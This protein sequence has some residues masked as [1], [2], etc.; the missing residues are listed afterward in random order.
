MK[1]IAIYIITYN[2]EDVIS[3][4]L[5]SILCQREW[6]LYRIVVSDDRS[7]DHTWEILQ[8]YKSQYPD[9]MDI[10]QNE[11]NLGIYPNIQKATSF[12]PECDLY[13]ALAGDDEYC[14]GY[15]ESIQKLIKEKDIDTSEAIG[16]YSDWKAI[17]PS[18][19]EIL[20]KQEIVKSGV[21]LWSLKARGLISKR[22]LLWSK[23][24]FDNYEPMLTGCGLNLI[25]SHYD[26][27]V[28]INIKTAYYMPQ[29]TTIYYAGIGVSKRLSDP[30]SA[31]NTTENIEKWNY[32]IEHYVQDKR[33]MHLAQYQIM[34][35]EYNMK[36]QWSTLFK[37]ML[38]YEK[39]LLPCCRNSKWNTIR[40]FLSYLKY[41][42]VFQ[43]KSI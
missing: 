10:H 30:L 20:H 43:N 17:E 2:Q 23:K 4:A 9:I 11:V 8:K 24:V 37:M 14:D 22:S 35:S 26:S 40:L 16:I 31:Y 5:D 19:N 34:H 6:G 25:E 13:G 33:D 32:G 39:S 38:H 27:Q 18:G 29:V 1:R 36:P 42:F 3:R 15:F 12:L 21:R 7:K 28:P 41:K